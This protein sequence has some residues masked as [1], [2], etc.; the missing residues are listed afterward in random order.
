MLPL[1]PSPRDADPTEPT[2][3]PEPRLLTR[4]DPQGTHPGPE[5][6]RVP[7]LQAKMA[8]HASSGPGGA[9][10]K[11]AGHGSQGPLA[12]SLARLR[13]ARLRRDQL[14]GDQLQQ[15]GP[16]EFPAQ[17][18]AGREAQAGRSWFLLAA[19]LLLIGA[20]SA[21]G[22]S[23]WLRH[24]MRAALPQIDGTLRVSGLQAEVHVLRDPQGVPSL[25]AASLNDLLF[26]QGFV[27]AGD[28]LWQMDALRRNAAGELAEVLGS[29]LIEHD[30]RQRLLQI[31]A[32]ADRAIA[33]LA[34]DQLDQLENY[35]RGVNAAITQSAGHLPIEFRLLHYRPAPWTPRDSLLVS[36]SMAQELSTSFPSKL[37]REALAMHLP[38][39]LL[40][41][42]YPVG[43]W[44]DR[45]P[46][47]PRVDLT[48]PR[49]VPEVPLDESQQAAALVTPAA[50]LVT[51]AA[52]MAQPGDLL[53]VAQ[54]LQ[55]C[56]ECRAGS[57]NWAV[58]PSRS[59]S[60]G[61]LLANDMHL[62]LSAPD[63]W[64]EASLH[65]Q[66]NARSGS[67]AQAL[68]T[69]GFTLPGVPF[70]IVGRNAHVAW[71]FTNLG[72]D[73]QDVRVE[74]LRGS[75]AATEF[76]RPDG[77]WQ[78][79]GHH[80]E[81]IR[82][83]GGHDVVLDVLT[84]IAMAGPVALETPIISPLYPSDRR[85][86]SLA[87]TV[88]DP[89][90]LSSPF[91]AVNQAADGASLVAA[92]ASFGAPSLNLVWADDA[93]HIGYH[94]TGRIPIRGPA[95]HHP[96]AAESFV[97]PDAV[98]E[99]DQQDESGQHRTAVPSES[100]E[101]QATLQPQSSTQ[102][103]PSLMATSYVP[104]GRRPPVAAGPQRHRSAIAAVPQHRTR[105]APLPARPHKPLVEAT[106][107][108]PAATLDYTIG[109]LLTG[110]PVDALNPAQA[111]SGYIAY[112]DLPSAQNPANGVLATANARVTANDYPY[113][114]TTDWVD[115]YRAER[116]YKLLEN[117]HGLTAADM[118]AVENDVHSELDLA[119]AHRLAYALDHASDQAIAGDRARLHGAADL[120]RRWK[121]DVRAGLAAPAIVAAVRLELLP[122][123]LAPQIATHDGLRPE[124]PQARALASL[125][126]SN[127]SGTA[128][129][130]LLQHTPARWLPPGFANWN[131]FLATATTRALEHAHA[132]RNLS[133][134]TY[135]SI[136]TVE[137][138]HPLLGAR[139]SFRYVLG[140]PAS[141]GVY[142][143]DG[144]GST[145]KAIARQ[146]GPNE[147]L[148]ADLAPG[149]ATLGNITTGQ[150]GNPASP[151]FMDQFL[152]WL[153]GT[154]FTLP[155]TTLPSQPGAEAHTLTLVP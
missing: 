18:Q 155:A 132:P 125:Y 57:N 146:F 80:P 24:A 144:D 30:R 7:F 85:A 137:I 39:A 123:L 28:R 147:R 94:A 149:S 1:S 25:T 79:A 73:V 141:S 62:S 78:P 52:A 4:S 145:V 95:V 110:M 93:G 42:L 9:H 56:A 23:L 101:P 112:A 154:T 33:V 81:R 143:A 120:L 100:S 66:P 29:S 82:V 19:A 61:A 59:A 13:R 2:P 88:Y 109:S 45:P 115:P 65:L 89:A 142:P 14:R 11:Q 77:G 87:W 108:P 34:P 117:R 46:T 105:T 35:A 64:Y 16:G 121:G 53:R 122:A 139:R 138:P 44:R 91:L 119:V 50:A 38:A 75:G 151:W 60:G 74:H 104:R 133:T 15:A 150:S 135:G 67:L 17:L 129:E 12:R 63:I 49:D 107:A 40:A 54:S 92:L 41:D 21:L 58:A 111:W 134:W 8:E 102:G 124:A 47:E 97:L 27:T 114:L 113:A 128:L 103:H 32:A 148:V 5:R 106:L 153:R 69:T 31:R 51:P 10:E 70:V 98:P 37:N 86:L 43:S 48:A 126:R 55:P 68:D 6:T 20:C 3:S 127:A 96:R 90:V 99:Q 71:G 130:L 116:I 72:G 22:L 136:H 84:T 83:R 131:D 140:A 36:L 76:Q 152:P 118:L 26:A